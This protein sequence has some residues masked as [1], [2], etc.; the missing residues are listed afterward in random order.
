M[1]YLLLLF[2]PLAAATALVVKV[3]TAAPVINREPVVAPVEQVIPAVVEPAFLAVESAEA[4]T[5]APEPSKSIAVV[6]KAEPV[7]APIPAAES[8]VP[9]ERLIVWQPAPSAQPAPVVVAPPA[10]PTPIPLPPPTPGASPAPA[11]VV[12]EPV[13]Q[14][15]EVPQEVK[16]VGKITIFG[17]ECRDLPTEYSLDDLLR[18]EGWGETPE[19]I[20]EKWLAN[21]NP[22]DE[23]PFGRIIVQAIV[24]QTGPN[25]L[26]TRSAVV[27]ITTS[28]PA[29]NRV[30]NGTGGVVRC[31]PY[32]ETVQGSGTSVYGHVLNVTERGTHFIKFSSVLNGVP[33]SET[34]TFVVR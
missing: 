7:A 8:V 18:G 4:T 34:Y 16:P 2:L 30:M 24:Q 15:V 11:P 5:T 29:Q 14:P 13:A 6:V 19:E 33:I 32:G 22:P 17:R 31:L 28:D 26:P 27:T 10:R 21:G 3:S 12:A 1:R 23:K 9:T 25:D 20:Q